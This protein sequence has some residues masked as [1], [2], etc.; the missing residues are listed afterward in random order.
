MS[1]FGK[2]SRLALAVSV[3]LSAVAWLLAGAATPAWIEDWASNREIIAN[4]VQ[5]IDDLEQ[6][7][8]AFAATVDAAI[9]NGTSDVELTKLLM[10][11]L[12]ELT[13]TRG[14]RALSRAMRPTAAVAVARYRPGR[15][16]DPS[17]RA[18]TG[19]QLRLVASR[20]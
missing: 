3:L 13:K 5:G 19:R 15:A 9:A 20:C 10:D 2:A 6:S 8:D 1:P 17:L 11:F 16:R 4:S 7:A 18:P 14:S 12:V